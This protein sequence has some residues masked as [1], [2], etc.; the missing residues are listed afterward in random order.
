MHSR[1]ALGLGIAIA[2][3]GLVLA[4]VL[5]P[6]TPRMPLTTVQVDL[7]TQVA[8]L[9]QQV[10]SLQAAVVALQ[11]KTQ[12]LN[13]NGVGLSLSSGSSSV[14]V[15]PAGVALVGTMLT[16]NGNGRPAAR[17]GDTVTGAPQGGSGQIVTGSAT[18]LIG[19]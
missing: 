5:T 18:V 16:L 9:Q 1:I 13:S 17:V 7:A 6:S 4:Q 2:G 14:T 12:L 10:A 19:N 3:T 11:S 8:T 15:S